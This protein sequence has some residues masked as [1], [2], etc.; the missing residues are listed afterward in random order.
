MPHA[1]PQILLDGDIGEQSGDAEHEP[2]DA[3]LEDRHREHQQEIPGVN[4]GAE[5][6][7]EAEDGQRGRDG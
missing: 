6:D 7:P 3:P 5:D 1:C 4:D 2:A